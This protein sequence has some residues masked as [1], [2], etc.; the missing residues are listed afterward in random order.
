MHIR[1]LE[2]N[3]EKIR[4]LDIRNLF[5][6]NIC[7]DSSRLVDVSHENSVSLR[8]C[9]ICGLFTYKSCNSENGVQ[10][11]NFTGNTCFLSQNHGLHVI[12]L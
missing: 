12:L 1:L 10:N 11:V 2:E 8:F 7:T 4:E 3:F 5:I 9:T 6:T